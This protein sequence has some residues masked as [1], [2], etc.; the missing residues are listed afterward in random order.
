MLKGD[1]VYIEDTKRGQWLNAERITRE[2]MRIA[3]TLAEVARES[4]RPPAQVA[5]N[6]VRQ[7]PGGIIPIVA[8]RTPEQMAQNL[9]C[10]DFRLEQQQLERLDAVSEISLGFPQ[11]FL[12]CEPLLQSLFGTKRDLFDFIPHPATPTNSQD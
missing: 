9:G 12:A 8:A 3:D 2:S 1:E 5:L 7:R 6:W 11:R 4:S 10:L